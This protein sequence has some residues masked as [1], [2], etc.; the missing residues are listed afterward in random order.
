MSTFSVTVTVTGELKAHQQV[1]LRENIRAAAGQT[2]NTINA[3]GTSADYEVRAG[4][5]PLAHI[6]GVAEL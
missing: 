3:S 4:L 2:V 1:A 6:R 5:A